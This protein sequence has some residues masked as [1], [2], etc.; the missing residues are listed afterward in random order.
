MMPLAATY[1]VTRYDGIINY[2]LLQLVSLVGSVGIVIVV[3][4]LHPHYKVL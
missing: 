2:I 3:L 4:F 1:R